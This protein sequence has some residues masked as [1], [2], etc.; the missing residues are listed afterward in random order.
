MPCCD[1]NCAISVSSTTSFACWLFSINVVQLDHTHGY[2]FRQQ[3]QPDQTCQFDEF[4]W[5]GL[6]F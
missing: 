4:H 2:P 1:L 6:G 3:Q 5:E